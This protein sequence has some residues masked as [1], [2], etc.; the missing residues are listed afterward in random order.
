MRIPRAST[1]AVGS[2]NTPEVVGGVEE[3]GGRGGCVARERGG[4]VELT[5]TD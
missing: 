4:A 1:V 2:R 3:G 5:I